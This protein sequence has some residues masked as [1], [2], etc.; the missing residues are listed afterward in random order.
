MKGGVVKEPMERDVL[1]GVL[2]KVR[3]VSEVG[4]WPRKSISDRH[5]AKKSPQSVLSLVP[6]FHTFPLLIM[7]QVETVHLFSFASS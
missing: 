2:S 5:Q 4:I 6:C 1:K 7:R 3:E